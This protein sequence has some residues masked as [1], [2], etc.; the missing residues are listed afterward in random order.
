MTLY[1]GLNDKNTMNQEITTDVAQDLIYYLLLNN[2]LDATI[3]LNNGIY[4]HKDTMS[5]TVENSFKIEMLCFENEKTFINKIKNI[6]SYLKT[7]LNQ[8]SIAV[9][10]EYLNSELW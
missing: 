7:C 10:K 2:E 1:V 4:T 6:V 9:V 5:I 8:E 3:S